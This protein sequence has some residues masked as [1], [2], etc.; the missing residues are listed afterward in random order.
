MLA[1]DQVVETIF[2]EEVAV[3]RTEALATPLRLKSE[4][5]LNLV[6]VFLF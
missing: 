4:V 1:E 2:I 5:D 3:I 6:F